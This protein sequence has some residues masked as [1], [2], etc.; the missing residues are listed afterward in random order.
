MTKDRADTQINNVPT[1]KALFKKG[2]LC[3]IADEYASLSIKIIITSG[4]K[5][6]LLLNKIQTNDCL[7]L[8][9]LSRLPLS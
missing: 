3:L 6:F 5:L 8:L 4:F 9:L 2:L 1:E 7:F